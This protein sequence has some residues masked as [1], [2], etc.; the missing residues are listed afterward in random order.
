LFCLSTLHLNRVERKEG[1]SDKAFVP[2]CFARQ[3]DFYFSVV[4]EIRE[5][6]YSLVFFRPM[7]AIF[8]LIYSS[9]AHPEMRRFSAV[10]FGL[11]L[12]VVVQRTSDFHGTMHSFIINFSSD[13]VQS[14]RRAAKKDIRTKPLY[15]PASRGSLICLRFVAKGR[16]R[17][18][19]FSRI[20]FCC[21]TMSD[22]VNSVVAILHR[23]KSTQYHSMSYDVFHLT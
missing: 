21:D 17:V 10:L 2:T 18:E 9:I 20:N 5:M 13:P 22:C 23:C 19:L 1:R 4:P 12:K 8:T 15:R 11:F 7:C 14:T 6:V 16:Q 3:L